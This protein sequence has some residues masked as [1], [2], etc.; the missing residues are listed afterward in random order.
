MCGGEIM[1]GKVGGSVKIFVGS[2]L[3]KLDS[4]IMTRGEI[5]VGNEAK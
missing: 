2:K 5:R 4:G 3:S 1:E